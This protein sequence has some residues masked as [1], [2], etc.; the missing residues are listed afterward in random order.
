VLEVEGAIGALFGDPLVLGPRP[1]LAK[2]EALQVEGGG[3]EEGGGRA[4]VEKGGEIMGG[5]TRG[6]RVQGQGPGALLGVA[7][8]DI[9]RV[10]LL[11][12]GIVYQKT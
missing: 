9:A 8:V 12:G 6:Q 4:S 10:Q 7:G 2:T 5:S 1:P 11:V 3:W